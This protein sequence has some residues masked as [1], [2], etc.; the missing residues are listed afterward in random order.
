MTIAYSLSRSFSATPSVLWDCWTLASHLE[1]WYSPTNLKVVPGS[2]SSSAEPSGVWAVG[3]DASEYGF[4]AYFFGVYTE[5]EPGVRLVHTMNYTQDSTEFEARQ[6]QD[7]AHLVE[8]RF[9]AVQDGCVVTFTQ[10]GEMPSEQTEQAKAG[11]ESY[12]DNLELYLGRIS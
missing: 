9:E 7:D 5:V 6:E 8:V 4:V 1:N 2:V 11:M 10:L 3:V 12:F